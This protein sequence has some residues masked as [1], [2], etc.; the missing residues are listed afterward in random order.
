MG[1][2]D[3]NGRLARQKIKDF[4][5]IEA[6]QKDFK[7]VGAMRGIGWTVLYQDNV[8]G[9][10]LNFWINEHDEGIRRAACRYWS[11]M[12]LNMLHARLRPEK[13]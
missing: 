2:D 10:L 1:A 3:S 5:S 7:A 13:S 8:S 9:R 4:G 11:W 12:S 6:W